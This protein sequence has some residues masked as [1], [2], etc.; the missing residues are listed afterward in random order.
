[1]EDLERRLTRRELFDLGR[2]VGASALAAASLPY[3]VAAQTNANY[4]NPKYTLTLDQVRTGKVSPQAYL[5]ERFRLMPE[6]Q[7]ARKSGMLKGFLYEPTDKELRERFRDLFRDRGVRDENQL[8][9]LVDSTVQSYYLSKE[10]APSA[11]ITP[12]LRPFFGQQVPQ[13]IAFPEGALSKPEVNN[14]A[15][16]RSLIKIQLKYIQDWYTILRLGGV[17]LSYIT[18]PKEFR[19]EFLRDFMRLRAEYEVLRDIFRERAETNKLSVSGEWFGV[20]AV[21]YTRY[22]YF[23]RNNPTTDLERT[24]SQLQIKEFEGIVPV[25]KGNNIVLY[26]NLFGKRESVVIENI[27]IDDIK[28]FF[29]R[30]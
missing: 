1:M 13:Y 14:D 7:E 20:R 17:N 19:T 21:N 5:D 30:N 16:V 15:D 4:Q 11:F 6:V 25:L 24:V 22:L 18:S 10:E 3:E 8:Q 9:S 2:R 29:S 23:V 28:S 26:F 12:T 27:A